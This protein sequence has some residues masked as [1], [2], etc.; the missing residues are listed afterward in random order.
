M[1]IYIP[2]IVEDEGP[3]AIMYVLN[4]T[5][6]MAKIAETAGL[7]DTHNNDFKFLCKPTS[8]FI[9]WEFINHEDINNQTE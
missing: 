6:T 1:F 3:P 5:N 7:K 8:K 4:F 2:T 9:E